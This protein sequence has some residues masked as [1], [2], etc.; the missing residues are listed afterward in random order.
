MLYN[1]QWYVFNHM[2]ETTKVYLGSKSSVLGLTRMLRCLQHIYI[3]EAFGVRVLAS[4]KT[5]ASH[6]FPEPNRPALSVTEASSLICQLS[7]AEL[8][9]LGA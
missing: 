4:R 6:R 7:G 1:Y 5:S 2:D 9:Q 3:M 8:G